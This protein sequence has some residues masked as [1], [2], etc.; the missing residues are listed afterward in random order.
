MCVY[1][2]NKKNCSYYWKQETF[3][4]LEERINY[5][6]KLPLTSSE[7]SFIVYINDH[8]TDIRDYIDILRLEIEDYKIPPVKFI[9]ELQSYI[10][11]IE[12]FAQIVGEPDTQSADPYGE[13]IC[14]YRSDDGKFELRLYD[15]LIDPLTKRFHPTPARIEETKGFIEVS[16]RAFEKMTVPGMTGIL[17]HEYFHNHRGWNSPDD[18]LEEMAADAYGVRVFEMLGFPKSE[19]VYALSQTFRN[20]SDQEYEKMKN[21]KAWMASHAVNEERLAEIYNYLNR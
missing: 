13:Y 11:L 16:K 15:Y 18:K 12:D 10:N 14:R 21:N 5:E 9:P 4:H 6:I 1:D 17:L 8:N 7:I 3:D 20:Y 19:F 2:H